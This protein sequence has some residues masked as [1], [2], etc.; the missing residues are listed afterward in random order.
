MH[1][2]EVA[3]FFKTQFFAIIKQATGM[4][5]QKYWLT[6]VLPAF[7]DG[8]SP[9]TATSVISMLPKFN[10]VRGLTDDEVRSIA[11]TYLAS[12]HRGA[13]LERELQDMKRWYNGY[14]FSVSHDNSA[15]TL[16]N[17]Q[18]VFTH[19]RRLRGKSRVEPI[20]EANSTH[21]ANVLEAIRTS[22]QVPLLRVLRVCA[23]GKA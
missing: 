6:G 2:D 20:D 7:R 17:P 21:S 15:P 10:G 22:T 3:E 11:T 23:L 4:V 19:L 14:K 13:D 1:F 18:L 8:I 9:L 5:V 12:T 16:Y